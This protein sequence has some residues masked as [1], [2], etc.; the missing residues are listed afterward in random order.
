MSLDKFLETQT[1]SFNLTKTT[2]LLHI[3][4]KALRVRLTKYYNSPDDTVRLV[5]TVLNAIYTEGKTTFHF[6]KRSLEALIEEDKKNLEC[7]N[8]P[9]IELGNAKHRLNF[10]RQQLIKVFSNTDSFTLIKDSSIANKTPACIEFIDSDIFDEM[11]ELRHMSAAL[12]NNW[13]NAALASI[14]LQEKAIALQDQTIL[15]S[16]SDNPRTTNNKSVTTQEEIDRLLK[17]TLGK[18]NY[19]D[20]TIDEGDI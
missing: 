19:F 13:K 7:K 18:S 12:K 16:I 14:E 20:C 2:Y 3:K 8:R 11:D 10:L 5:G 4:E 15:E 17:S 9:K 1:V 6:S